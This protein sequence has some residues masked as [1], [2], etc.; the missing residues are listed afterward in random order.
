MINSHP[1]CSRLAIWKDIQKS[2]VN[3]NSQS[4]DFTHVILGQKN[5][6]TLEIYGGKKWTQ[7]A[8]LY[9]CLITPFKGNL[10]MFKMYILFNPEILLGHDPVAKSCLPRNH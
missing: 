4:R 1:L 8:L 5:K 6:I 3:S 9:V 7:S 2:S 10:T